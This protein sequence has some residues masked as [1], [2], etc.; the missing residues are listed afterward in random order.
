MGRKSR[1]AAET[2]GEVLGLKQLIVR[3]IKHGAGINKAQYIVRTF[4]TDFGMKNGSLLD[5]LDILKEKGLV[6]F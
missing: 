1:R 6:V 4:T 5:L 3:T 2:A